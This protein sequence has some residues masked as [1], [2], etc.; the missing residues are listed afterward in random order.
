MSGNGLGLYGA[1]S[2]WSKIDLFQLDPKDKLNKNKFS[3]WI[4]KYH[5]VCRW[6]LVPQGHDVLNNMNVCLQLTLEHH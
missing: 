5:S 4:A 2:F 6:R 1:K 3:K